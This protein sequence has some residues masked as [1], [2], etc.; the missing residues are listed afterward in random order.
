MAASARSTVA[1]WGRGLAGGR[2]RTDP[3]PH[4]RSGFVLVGSLG[5]SYVAVS[6]S[7][8]GAAMRMKISE[9]ARRL[10]VSIDTVRRLE[11]K[12]LLSPERDW[13]GHRRFSEADVERARRALFASASMRSAQARSG[14]E[15]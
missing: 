2:S 6:S 5:A 8:E 4:E 14:E 10:E 1:Y 9:F 7:T 12:G 15:S 3:S 11:R 13:A